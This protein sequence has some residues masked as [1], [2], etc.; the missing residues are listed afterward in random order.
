MG[1]N[2]EINHQSGPFKS[3]LNSLYVAG[4]RVYLAEDGTQNNKL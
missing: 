4:R 2:V 3:I 1:W